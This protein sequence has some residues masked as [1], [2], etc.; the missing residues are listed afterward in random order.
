MEMGPTMN[1]RT[2]ALEI[3]AAGVLMTRPMNA[4]A[5]IKHKNICAGK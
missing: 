5:G 2:L 1:T 4:E 3:L